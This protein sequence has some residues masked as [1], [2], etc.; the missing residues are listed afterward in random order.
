MTYS[1]KTLHPIQQNWLFLHS[2]IPHRF[3]GLGY[4]D[5][6]EDMGSFPEQIDSWIESVIAGDVIKSI[7]K[8]GKTGVGLLFAGAPG[9]GKTTHAVVAAMELIRRLPQDENQMRM[10]FQTAPDTSLSLLRPIYYLT[11]P[12][13]LARKKGSWDGDADTKA[14]AQLE[15][16]GLHGRAKADEYN[17]RVLILDDLGK[18]YGSSF[19]D[20]SFDE[21]LRSRYDKGL[22]T[23]ITTNKYREDWADQYGAAMG[24]FA[25]EAFHGVDIIGKDLRKG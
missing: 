14:R 9:L 10:I 8:L 3:M 6:V 13:F 15:I 17:A 12:E 20:A 11:Y 24:S 22:P 23:I 2:N 18:E 25:F 16:D 5:I 4:E 1:F 21:V 7:G 19:D